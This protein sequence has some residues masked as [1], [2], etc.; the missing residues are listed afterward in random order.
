MDFTDIA[1]LQQ[2][3]TRQREAYAVLAGNQIM[4]RLQAFDPVL[5]G[6]IPIGVDIAGSDLD[7]LCCFTDPL[8]F[9][10][11]IKT[12]FKQETGFKIRTQAMPG[13]AAV[14]AGFVCDAFEIE[15]FGQQLPVQQQYGYRHMLVEYAL[16]QRFGAPLRQQVIALKQQGYKTEPAFALALGLEGDPYEALLQPGML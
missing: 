5:A 15:I 11:V 10:E 7:I 1:Y 12:C 14:I 3:N 16:L 9:S 4:E 6:T 13:G 2:G 8:H